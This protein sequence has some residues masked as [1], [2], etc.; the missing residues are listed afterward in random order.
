[1]RF[2]ALSPRGRNPCR[3]CQ[4]S[5]INYRLLVA[6]PVV[7]PAAAV[8]SLTGHRQVSTVFARCGPLIGTARP[9][10]KSTNPDSTPDSWAIAVQPG[11]TQLYSPS[12]QRQTH[13]SLFGS[14]LCILI[15]H[16]QY[17]QHLAVDSSCSSVTSF[18]QASPR[19]IPSRCVRS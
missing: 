16:P 12:P 18:C 19:H 6:A 8:R 11:L 15:F 5:S 3:S 10:Q 4:E 1:M 7:F 13:L 9:D 2:S 14:E 17:Q